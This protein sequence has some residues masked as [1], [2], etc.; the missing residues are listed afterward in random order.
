MFTQTSGGANL[1]YRDRVELTETLTGKSCLESCI[2]LQE[3]KSRHGT[4]HASLASSRRIQGQKIRKFWG[5][6]ISDVQAYSFISY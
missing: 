3:R 1:R 6:T 2:S 4:E 5:E